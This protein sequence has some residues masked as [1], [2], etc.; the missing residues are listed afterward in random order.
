MAEDFKTQLARVRSLGMCTD[1]ASD[2][3]AAINAVLMMYSRLVGA[4]IG[5]Q[6]C[7]GI[8]VLATL[9]AEADRIPS[10]GEAKAIL[11]SKEATNV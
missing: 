3:C 10:T 8:P 9:I 7:L 5:A 6:A 2:D 4:I 1:L 11:G